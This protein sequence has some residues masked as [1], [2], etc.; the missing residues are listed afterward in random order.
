MTL[1]GK[2]WQ[3]LLLVTTIVAALPLLFYPNSLRVD[4]KL[5]MGWYIVLEFVYFY[6]LF[7]LLNP[8]ISGSGIVLFVVCG[9]WGRL[10]VSAVFFLFL[11]LMGSVNA[12]TALADAFIGYKPALL[13]FSLTAPALYNSTIK[14]LLPVQA[15]TAKMNQQRPLQAVTA[16]RPVASTVTKYDDTEPRMQL[17]R[18]AG[19]GAD[20]GFEEAVRHV[21]GYSGVI[22]ALVIDRDGLLVARFDRGEEDVERWAGLGLKIVA[23][24]A[25]TLKKAG[26]DDPEWLKFG[27]AGKRFYLLR[28]G[29]MWLLSI[30]TGDDLEKIRMQQA[31]SMVS[32]YYQQKYEC[33]LSSEMEKNYA[34]STVRA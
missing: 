30:A 26:S 24:L 21:A 12:T 33:V 32:K 19:G 34:G 2:D 20:D 18:L 5:G 9:L 16:A 22:C 11:L 4:F 13:L 29:D 25:D 31:A 27:L 3:H 23:D 28:A 7:R 6:I 10:L 1:A 17:S 8:R 15:P 14:L